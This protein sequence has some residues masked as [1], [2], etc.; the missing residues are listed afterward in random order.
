MKKFIMF[1]AAAVFAFAA[2][3]DPDNG[4]QLCPDC[5]QNPCVC[6]SGSSTEL[7]LDVTVQLQHEVNT[8]YTGTTATIDGAKVL[9]F[10]E[11]ENVQAYYEA[12]GYLSGGGQVENTLMYGTCVKDGE[13]WLYTFNPLTSSNIGHWF[14]REGVMTTWGST[15]APQYFF[16]ESQQWMWVG[17]WRVDDPAAEDDTW[18]YD[19]SWNYTVGMEAGYYD[20]NVGDKLS[21]VEFIFEESTG[22][23]LYIHWNIEIVDYIDPELGQYDGTPANKEATIDLKVG[24]PVDITPIQEAFQL[25]KFEFSKIVADQIEVTN[26]IDDVQV[27]WSAGGFG[28][29]WF[30]AEGKQTWW[31]TGAEDDPETPDVNEACTPAVYYIELIATAT[32]IK[33]Y[34]GYYGEDSAAQ[35]A[36]KSFNNFKQVVTYTPAEGE[37]YTCTL[38]YNVTF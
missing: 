35:V 16:T 13:D 14:T 10:F 34:S 8:N 11:L 36:G 25:T 33:A 12:M 27:E 7:H 28:G 18:S 4:G 37:S 5:G 23:T 6:T 32:E 26:F 29:V 2:C 21:A 19:L 22:K 17:D 38:N 31:G 20:L 30:D 24:T 1:V 15:E 3:E 9:E